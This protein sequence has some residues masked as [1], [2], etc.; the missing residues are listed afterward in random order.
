MRKTTGVDQTFVVFKFFFRGE[1]THE[2]E[3]NPQLITLTSTLLL[4]PNMM[5]AWAIA[6]HSLA[7]FFISTDWQT[8]LLLYQEPD[9]VNHNG[10]SAVT[11]Q[12]LPG[13]HLVLMLGPALAVTPQPHNSS[14]HLR[15]PWLVDPAWQSPQGEVA[16][17]QREQLPRCLFKSALLFLI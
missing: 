13:L 15:H 3:K 10:W 16:S 5:G 4:Q 17:T 12:I 7:Q 2:K 9:S 8:S 1:K 14:L 11:A 6:G